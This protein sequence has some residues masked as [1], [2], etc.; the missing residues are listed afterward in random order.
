L[1][2][3]PDLPVHFLVIGELRKGK[4]FPPEE[5]EW[6]QWK[7]FVDALCDP[8]TEVHAYGAT[9]PVGGEE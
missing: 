5:E 7:R 6:E 1:V 2:G 4:P 9:A 3:G 8:A